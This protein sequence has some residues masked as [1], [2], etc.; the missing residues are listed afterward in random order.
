MRSGRR[1]GG[2]V[3]THQRQ[4]AAIL[5]RAC[6]V[7]V[8]ENVAA[9]VN[10]RTFAIPKRENAVELAFAAHFCLLRAPNG[11]CGQILIE[12]RLEQN[13]ILLKKQSRRE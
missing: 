6:K 8:T 9:P 3:V 7:H 12:A 4:H 13:V 11:G 1:F 10:A 2:V 5:R